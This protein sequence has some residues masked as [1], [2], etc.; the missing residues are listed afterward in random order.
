LAACFD[1]SVTEHTPLSRLRHVRS[2]SSLDD[3]S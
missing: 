2:P 3:S 1:Q